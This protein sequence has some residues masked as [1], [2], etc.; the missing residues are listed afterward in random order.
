MLACIIYLLS[1]YAAYLFSIAVGL[2]ILMGLIQTG[3]VALIA[4]REVEISKDRIKINDR[5]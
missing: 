3:F 1:N 4:K 5:E 2:L